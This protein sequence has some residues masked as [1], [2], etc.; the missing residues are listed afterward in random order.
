GLQGVNPNN[1]SAMGFPD[2]FFNDLTSLVQQ[3]GGVKGRASELF[4][5]WSYADSVT[6]AKGRHVMKFGEELRAY[7][8]YNAY[9][10]HGAFGQFS[11][12]G[13]FTGYDYADFLLGLPF[14]STRLNPLTRR[15][16]WGRELGVFA[17]DTFKVTRKL[18]LDYGIRWDHFGAFRYD[19]GLQ[20]NFDP[21]QNAVVVPPSALSHVSP[22][23]PSDINVVTGPVIPNPSKHNFVPRLG[24]AYL[25]TEKTVVRG[26]YGIF[27]SR[28]LGVFSLVEGAGPFTL[29]ENYTNTIQNG[30]ALFAFPNPF[31]ANLGLVEVPSQAVSGYLLNTR[32]GNIHQFNATVEHHLRDIGLRLSYVG[33]RTRSLNGFYEANK[34]Q[35]S[36]IPFSPD[37]RP[38]PQ[39][40]S[41]ELLRRDLAANYDSLTLEARR[42]VGQVSFEG[43]WTWA[44]NLDN[45]EILSSGYGTLY[46]PQYGGFIDE[47]PYAPLQWNHDTVTPHHR[48]VVSANWDIPVGRGRRFLAKA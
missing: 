16:Q 37:R 39:F 13:S 5:N 27:T 17:M 2:M 30:Q 40:V 26:G 22:L 25:I 32:D 24:A 8:N 48:V 36:T 20:Y 14:S 3:A 42:R 15:T 47:N 35:P 33:S 44:N 10:P 18:T 9:I 45:Y 28:G 43:F 7:M 4:E 41:V 12:N 11:F 46:G 34:P 19:D 21:T 23:Y 1:Y 31:P 6:W 29:S 38:Y